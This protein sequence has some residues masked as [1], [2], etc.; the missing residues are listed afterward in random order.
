MAGML[1][2]SPASATITLIA[3]GTL[4]DSAAGH[5]ADLSG[6][7]GTLENG[8]PANLLGG[9]G[10][11]IAYAGGNT[12]LAVPDRGPN[13][14]SYNSKVDDTVFYIN[15]FQ[16]LTMSLAPS[17]PG[18]ALPFTL[19]PTLTSTTLLSSPTPL[20]YGTGAGLGL[21]SGAPAQNTANKFYFTGRSDNFDP[22]KN[23]GN[24]NNARFDPES[25]RVSNDGKSVFISDEYGPYVYQFDRATGQRIKSF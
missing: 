15:R 5:L 23:S 12:F 19:T 25:I 10:S 13:A 22:N 16:T 14:V 6:L 18:T 8:A 3:D 11:G 9:L 1:A 17:A 21:G 24:P 4:T 7:T 20:T 2:A